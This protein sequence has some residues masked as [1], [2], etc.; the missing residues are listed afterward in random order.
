MARYCIADIEPMVN[1]YVGSK[2]YNQPFG[3]RVHYK[4][5]QQRTYTGYPEHVLC[6]LLTKRQRA[7]AERLIVAIY[8]ARA[9]VR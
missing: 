6:N 8:N 4:G 3:I 9:V 1:M 2:G 7:Y 5:G